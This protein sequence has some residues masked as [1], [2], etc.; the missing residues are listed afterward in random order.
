MHA[1]YFFWACGYLRVRGQQ[2]VRGHTQSD[3]VFFPARTRGSS[4]ASRRI[5]FTQW[6]EVFKY[7]RLFKSSYTDEHVPFWLSAAADDE[8]PGWA[9]W[10]DEQHPKHRSALDLSPESAVFKQPQ[11][12]MLG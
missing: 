6:P 12:V 4:E 7:I 3:P 8:E 5:R 1:H 9:E 10:H 2:H 11:S